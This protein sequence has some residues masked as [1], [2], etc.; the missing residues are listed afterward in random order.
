MEITMK[1]K[2]ILLFTA[3]AFFWAA[4]INAQTFNNGGTSANY[5][6][7]IMDY[8]DC[9]CEHV[10]VQV[11][12]SQ[13]G[14]QYQHG[15]GSRFQLTHAF[16]Y[17]HHDKGFRGYFDIGDRDEAVLHG[18]MYSYQVSA[19]Y[20]FNDKW[21]ARGYFK[22]Q[23]RSYLEEHERSFYTD[24]EGGLMMQYSN[25][26]GWT[27]GGG[28]AYSRN[29]S[30]GLVH[31]IILMEYSNRNNFKAS[32][33]FPEIAEVWFTPG[34]RLGFGLLATLEGDE[35]EGR[36]TIY[37]EE[38]TKVQYSDFTVGPAMRV[39]VSSHISLNLRAAY[40]AGRHLV[41]QTDDSREYLNPSPV[42]GIR[43]GI[44]ISL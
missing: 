25:G 16:S 18:H 8:S 6:V 9:S 5:Q 26:S 42:W 1:T 22:P 21:S 41:I 44:H 4:E 17:T 23:V 34:N 35:F 24:Y 20:T 37:N 43:A 32:I 36:G 39:H 3:L 27:F 15:V 29:L 30:E 11:S 13:F 33:Y 12:V 10:P 2:Q 40:T 19:S 7:N 28:Y 31:P 14:L 38:K